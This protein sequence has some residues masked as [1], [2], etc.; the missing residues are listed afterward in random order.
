MDVSETLGIPL[1]EIIN[2]NGWALDGVRAGNILYFPYETYKNRFGVKTTAPVSSVAQ[3]NSDK[4]LSTPYTST[5]RAA[6]PV[7]NTKTT[8]TQKQNGKTI[9]TETAKPVDTAVT[10]PKHG[11][12]LT[13]VV[14]ELTH[15]SN[16][17]SRV[18][19]ANSV[20]AEAVSHSVEATPDTS[21][22][23]VV[24]P[25]NLGN[26]RT[27]RAN[28][29]T[30]FYRGFLIAAD[31][32]TAGSA[33]IKIKTI[34]AG[35]TAADTRSALDN[36]ALKNATIIIG[37]SDPDQF[38]VLTDF[39]RDHE[40]YLINP[41]IVKD[42]TYLTNPHVIQTYIDQK[43]M[44]EKAADYFMSLL[45]RTPE[46][47]PVLLDNKT[48][49]KNKDELVGMILER[50]NLRGIKPQTISYEGTL[51][52]ATIKSTIAENGNY[53]I[54]PQSGSLKEFNR[55]APNLS[56]FISTVSTP[57]NGTVKVFGYPEW[58]AF[59]GTP[60]ANL[61]KIDAC[62]YSRFFA[63]PNS[64][65]YQGV[66]DAYQRWYGRKLPVEIPIQSLLGF[67]TGRFVLSALQLG[68][69]GLEAPASYRGVQSS[70]D[71]Q[72]VDS[73]GKINEALYIIEYGPDET[74]NVS[75]R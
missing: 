22:V 40:T 65:D 15:I 68:R 21:I 55:F 26:E 75:L 10:V 36:P 53:L 61:S 35:A 60:R 67:D 28:L 71:F 18:A 33:P 3:S 31:T 11:Q 6:K 52:L 32:L 30:D 16:D 39:V 47:I 72:D 5:P 24:L 58:T 12:K 49:D 23:A 34:D 41:F 51:P 46:T 63:D 1:S 57:A 17:T 9:H 2:N 48:G 62:I 19:G 59:K 13:P 56:K 73:G 14:E 43:T 27:K 42:S 70:F 74:V 64:T 8:Q 50:L 25:L 66:N 69:R 38:Q 29:A 20:W 37:S 54:L 45:D 4:Q 44:Y 7:N